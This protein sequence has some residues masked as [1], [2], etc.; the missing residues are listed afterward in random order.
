MFFVCLFSL[1]VFVTFGSFAFLVCLVVGFVLLLFSD[2]P[3]FF[4]AVSTLPFSCLLLYLLMLVF[5]YQIMLDCSF[6]FMYYL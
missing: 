2:G 5:G 3:E 4:R 1:G 6:L